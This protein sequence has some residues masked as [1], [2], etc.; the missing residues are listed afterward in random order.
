MQPVV[1]FELNEVPW[2]IIDWWVAANPTSATARL[3]EDSSQWTSVCPDEGHLSPWVTWPTLH[4]GVPNTVHGIGHFGQDT[5]AA[6][7]IAPTWWVRAV[8]AG[9]R[10]GVFGLLHTNELPPDVDRYAFFVPD[11]FAPS[12]DTHPASLESFQAF[13]LSMARASARNVSTS[14]DV[15][16]ARRFLL[17]APRLGLRPATVVRLVRQLIDERRR[18]TTRVRRRSYQSVLAFDLFVGQL[19]SSRPDAAAFFTNH[20][21][22]AM[23]RYWAATFPGDYDPETFGFDAAWIDTWSGEI[24]EAMAHADRMLDRLRRHCDATGAALVVASSMGQQA[25][26]GTPVGRQL[27]LR[28]VDAFV[29]DADIDPAT[30]ERRPAMDPHVN[31]QIADPAALDLLRRRLDD[32]RIG[33]RELVWSEEEHGFVSMEFGQAD[34]A[35]GAVTV[36]GQARTPAELGLEVIEIEDEVASTGYHVPGGILFTYDPGSRDGGTSDAVDRS[37]SVVSTTEIASMILE[38]LGV[39]RE[40][41]PT[42]E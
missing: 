2:R 22:S 3:L 15:A 40:G 21:A 33:G 23:H 42:T 37:R 26:Q 11:T 5:S 28:D 18:P 34:D 16:A 8:Q 32:L 6:D 13:N 41:S 36:G 17:R 20:V 30:V 39:A 19:R 7:E 31:V 14:I 12:A 35:I 1:V 29:T 4:R 38:R 9:R 27:Y 10:V 25:A 24:A